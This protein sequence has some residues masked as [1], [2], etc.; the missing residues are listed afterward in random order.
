MNQST[1]VS[2]NLGLDCVALDADKL[3]VLAAVDAEGV[4]PGHT[5]EGEE[6]EAP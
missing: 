6:T 3:S 4:T 2:R 1:T 5:G